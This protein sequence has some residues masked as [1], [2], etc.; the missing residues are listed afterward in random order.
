LKNCL[1][2]INVVNIT[3]ILDLGNIEI[4]NFKRNITLF[5]I[6]PFFDEIISNSWGAS[7]SDSQTNNTILCNKLAQ[8]EAI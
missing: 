4:P 2:P 1:F 8:I 3:T 6:F 5:L 7:K